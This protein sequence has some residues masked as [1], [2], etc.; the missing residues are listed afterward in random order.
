MRRGFSALRTA[1]TRAAKPRARQDVLHF[2]LWLLP[3]AR[4]VVPSELATQ[5]ALKCAEIAGGVSRPRAHPR[6]QGIR[7]GTQFLE[8]RTGSGPH[9][10]RVWREWARCT[11]NTCVAQR[12]NVDNT[13]LGTN[14][15]MRPAV[16]RQR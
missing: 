9:Q 1:H 11:F 16:L 14:P 6:K 4:A 5:L 3:S 15:G 2:T 10:H 8:M 12:P 13:Q 7:T